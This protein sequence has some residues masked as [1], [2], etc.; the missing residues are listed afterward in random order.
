ELTFYKHYCPDVYSG[1][2][3]IVR[4]YGFTGIEP[5]TVFMGWVKK[6]DRKLQFERLMKIFEK[7]NISSVFLN[8][9]NSRAFG[10]QR[11]ID[12][13]WKG[14]DR[15]L[16]F[17]LNIIRH[18]TASG[19]WKDAKV[20]VL[21]VINRK[22]FIEKAYL[23]LNEIAKQFRITLEIKVI[24][25]SVDGYPWSEIVKRESA[26]TDLT[27]LGIQEKVQGQ[28]E[29][30][31][32]E[33]NTLKQNLGSLLLIKAGSLFE[34]YNLGIDVSQKESQNVFDSMVVLPELAMTKYHVINDDITK[35]D[36]N[37]QKELERFYN[38]SFIPYY[39]ESH[40]FF[41]E[42]RSLAGNITENLNKILKYSELTRRSRL[43][44]KTKND[45]YYHAKRV[46]EKL[47]NEKLI[48]QKNAL[49]DGIDWYIE[50]LDRDIAKFP[51]YLTVHYD[52]AD[53]QVKKTDSASLKWYKTRKRI[54][55]PFAKTTIPV[56]IKYKRVAGYYLKS[57]RYYF[58]HELLNKFYSE[59][60]SVHSQLRPLIISVD[61]GLEVLERKINEKKFKPDDIGEFENFL[62]D[63]IAAIE[64]EIS[65]LEKLNRNRLFVEYRKNI[66]ALIHDFE[67]IDINHIVLRKRKSKKY[68]KSIINKISTFSELWYNDSLSYFNK[69][70]LDVLMQSYKNRIRDKLSEFESLFIQ[71]IEGGLIKRITTIKSKLEKIDADF[72]GVQDIRLSITSADEYFHI[73]ASFEAIAT[74]FRKLEHDI[75]DSLTLAEIDSTDSKTAESGKRDEVALPLRKITGY[76][77]ETQFIGSVNDILGKTMEALRNSIFALKDY[78]SLTRFNLEN[79]GSETENRKGLIARI[80]D[81]TITKLTNIEGKIIEQ[82]RS[83]MPAINK[84]LEETFD[85]LSSFKIKERV[86]EYSRFSI[87]DQGK[88]VKSKFNISYHYIK[89]FIKK[90]SARLLYS[91]SEGILLA[92]KIISERRVKSKN[93]N[94]LDIIDNLV[95]HPEVIKALPH[96]Y[97]NLFSGRSSIVDDFWISRHEEEAQFDKSIKRFRTG[98]KGGIL[99]LGER[100]SGKTALCRYITRTR[101]KEDKVH[102]VFPLPGGSVNTS[103][104]TA[105]VQKSTNLSVGLN[106]IFDTLPFGSVIVIHDLELWWERS[107]RGFEVIKLILELI[108]K[109]DYKFLFIVNMNPFAYE[110][111]NGMLTMENHFISIINCRPFNS[112]ELKEMVMRRHRSSGLKFKIRKKH[113]D[114]ISEIS[115][116]RLFNKYFDESEGNPGTVLYHWLSNIEKVSSG[117]ISIK[118]PKNIDLQPIESIGDE[119][120][121]ILVQLLLQKRIP[122]H[123]LERMLGLEPHITDEVVNSMIQTGMIE[124]RPGK[125]LLINP[126]VEPFVRK[127]L[128]RKG[129]V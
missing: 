101:F 40:N 33:V 125:L 62:I 9:D 23:A 55:H 15:N 113:E 94:I 52:K 41:N 98:V 104:F 90:K 49:E 123:T 72:S 77:V 120:L 20:R 50:Q 43:I 92:R 67:K 121:V 110:L 54:I 59:L 126:Y 127:V 96:Y 31:Y 36:L 70:Y 117:T 115:L 85:S 8:Y 4:V 34:A 122:L 25:N 12:I 10:N 106:E 38:K 88:F 1:M 61:E 7:N 129:L 71:E 35:I 65:D 30:I 124:E 95:P 74:E 28:F 44:V 82:R 76:V 75:P 103:D 100:N 128:K 58:I 27:I 3:E 46:L 53:F 17:A 5:N 91:K 99:L 73:I 13:W 42:L 111:I 26:E 66:Q 6:Q 86:E 116:A 29:H 39:T 105:Q 24:N 48:I 93:E 78:L 2:D 22:A 79:I 60:E 118:P 64:S 89:N 16:A 80:M 63:R 37:G 102:A 114:H 18:L 109:F 47:L 69:I 108:A 32:S 84:K 19:D 119:A 112:E 87:D 21:I 81:E 14:N 83:L 68:D 97:K 107:E 51:N 57:T 45:F 56:R 11:T